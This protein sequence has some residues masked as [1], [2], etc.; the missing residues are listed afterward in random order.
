MD[1]M[2]RRLQRRFIVIATFAVVILLTITLGM[3]NFFN[4]SRARREVNAT[5]DMLLEHEG[6]FP[7]DPSALSDEKFYDDSE[8]A[9]YQTR[10]F[11]VRMTEQGESRA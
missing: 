5:M 8:E 10:Y 3:V 2:I 7:E 6:I 11:S 1:G 9:Y 4:F